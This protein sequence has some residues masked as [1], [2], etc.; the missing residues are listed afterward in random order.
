MT[1]RA[2]RL[3]LLNLDDVIAELALHDLRIADL[4]GEDGFVELRHHHA[5]PG[6]AQFAAL[7]F[8]AGVVGVLPGQ[9]GKVRAA[10]DLLEQRL[11]LGFGRGVGLGVGA[12]RHLDEDVA[13][14]GLLRNRVLGLVRIEVLLN[15]LLAGLR[16]A[17]GQLVGGKGKVGDLALLGH[18]RGIA[19][20]VLLEESLQIAVRGIDRLAQ[21]VGGDHRVVELDLDVLLAIGLADIRIAHRDSGGDQRLLTGG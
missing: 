19:R 5:A 1:G 21:I 3:P 8:A 10:L 15:L 12:G 13:R 9:V 17:A 4:L 7:V 20:G 14:T 16:N 6:K 18:G 2:C 11:G